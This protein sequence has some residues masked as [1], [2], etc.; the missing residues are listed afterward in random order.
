MGIGISQKDGSKRNEEKKSTKDE[1]VF[2]KGI[3]GGDEMKITDQ[4]AAYGW[5]ERNPFVF[6]NKAFTIAYVGKESTG[7]PKGKPVKDLLASGRKM[8]LKRLVPD[9]TIRY[10]KDFGFRTDLLRSLFNTVGFKFDPEKVV[11]VFNGSSDTIICQIKKGKGHMNF[12][13]APVKYQ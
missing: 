1:N 9:K 4:L 11:L 12:L 3:K 6:V 7:L 2:R 13:F 8:R 5:Q 10:N